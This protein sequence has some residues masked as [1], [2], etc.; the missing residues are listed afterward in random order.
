MARTH[1]ALTM[2]RLM[3]ELH[4]GEMVVPAKQAKQLRG[5]SPSEGININV[6]GAQGQDVNQLADIVMY[7]IQ[8]AFSRREAARA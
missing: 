1:P 6:Y 2:Y 3:A 8:N 7:K 5:N 4:K